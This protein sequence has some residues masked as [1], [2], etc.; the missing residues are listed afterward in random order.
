MGVIMG[1]AAYMA[2]EQAKGRPV[3]R[4]ADIWAFGVV[5][6]EMLT[7]RR[8][9]EAEDISDTLAAVLTRDVDWQALPA[10][11]PARLRGLV[12]DCLA[13]DP[14][15]RLR[16]IGEARRVLDQLISG[17]PEIEPAPSSIIA[18]PVPQVP[19]WRR[20]LPWAIAALAILSA[21]ATAWTSLSRPP[22]R[23]RHVTRASTPQDLSGFVG[24][25]RDGT[26]LAYTV[27]GAQG[28]YIALRQMDQFEAKGLAGTEN[29]GWPLFSP[30]G[31]WI[32]FSS[33]AAPT[34]IRK[35]QSRAARRSR[36]AT[37]AFN[38]AGLEQR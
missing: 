21:A 1:T 32:A 20:A 35:C 14:K 26:K 11:T 6:Y 5:L 8:G 17:A 23:A 3:D 10:D 36:S 7:G 15:N 2:P 29:S 4:R 34:K 33:I 28:F 13:R 30:D 24:L 12:R 22:L 18:V 31:E 25:S 38:R 19:A 27:S 9:Y 37:A 16:D